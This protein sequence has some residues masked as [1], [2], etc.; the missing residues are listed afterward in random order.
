MTKEKPMATKE[1]DEG[2]Q[3]L[4]AMIAELVQTVWDCLTL[5]LGKKTTRALLNRGV[6]KCVAEYPWLTHL[7]PNEEGP[8]LASVRQPLVLPGPSTF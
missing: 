2:K 1:I 4:L 5:I 3:E 8:D 7:R 6:D